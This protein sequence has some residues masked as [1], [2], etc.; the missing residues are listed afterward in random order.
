MDEGD[1]SLLQRLEDEYVTQFPS[2]R[3]REW[4]WWGG[5]RVSEGTEGSPT[6]LG[7][8][9]ETLGVDA[10]VTTESGLSNSSRRHREGPRQ[11]QDLLDY[12]DLRPLIS[13]DS[14]SFL[15]LPRSD[16]KTSG[17]R[18]GYPGKLSTSVIPTLCCPSLSSVWVQTEG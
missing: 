6:P 13:G 12:L 1:G 10:S 17:G 5:Q 14:R 3:V 11:T 4:G 8:Q 18:E 16:W 9:G 2:K 7:I 15:G